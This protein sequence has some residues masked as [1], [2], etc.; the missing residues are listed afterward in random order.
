MLSGKPSAI[1]PSRMTSARR[2]VHCPTQSPTP[3][4]RWVRTSAI[5]ARPRVAKIVG[6]IRSARVNV[7][8]DAIVGRRREIAAL[9]TWLEEARGGA[10]R[11]VL[12]AGEPGIG[13]SR[14]GQELAGAALASG[15][16]VAWGRCA[17]D[18]GAP[19]FWPWRQ[20]LGSLGV[21]ADHVLGAPIE[22]PEDRF[23][24]FEDV[25]AAVSDAAA[26]RALVVIL[27]DI[28]WADDPSL[29]VLRHVAQGL[30]ERPVLVFAAFRDV[31]P[32]SGLP[33]VLPDLLRAPGAERLDLRGF[34]LDEVREQLAKTA[35]DPS[36][37][38][39]AVLDL[40]GGNPLFVREVA[41]AMADGTWRPD[42]PPRSVLDLVR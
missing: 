29:L 26:D 12:C 3:S 30:A 9:R 14:L 37:N 10:G 2:R 38:A 11:L 35:D 28:H 24:V 25:S 27:D 23:R 15:A 5:A 40:T 6:R 1:R 42:R 8:S 39:A 19:A 33:S 13:K 20:V 4:P 21:D 22:S 31:E 36:A 18:E 7:L 17:R 16:A 41:R 32:E 34:D